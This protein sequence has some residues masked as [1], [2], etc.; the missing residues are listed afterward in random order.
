MKLIFVVKYYDA[1]RAAFYGKNKDLNMLTYDQLMNRYLDDY[2]S[3]YSSL[4]RILRTRGHEA[5]LIIPNCE[6]IRAKWNLK[7]GLKPVNSDKEYISDA[8]DFY[9][10]DAVFLNSNFEYC[11]DFAAGIRKKVKALFCWISCPYDQS[12]NL[13]PFNTIF[14][15]FPPHH[16]TF[17][18]SGLHSKLVTAGFDPEV[19]KNINPDTKSSIPFS[20]VGGIGG[21]HKK[22]EKYLKQIAKNTPLQ[23][24]GYGYSSDHLLKRILKNVKNGFTY[25]KNY[26]GQAWGVDMFQVLNDSQIT[27]NIHG[28]IAGTYSVNM[29]LFEATGMGTMLLTDHADNISELFTPGVE[30]V[31]FRTPEEAIEKYNYYSMHDQERK[32]IAAAG[33][34]K[35]LELYNYNNIADIFIEEFTQSIKE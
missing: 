33:Q 10:P 21:F 9:K 18:K 4:I 20:F 17:I 23:I 30:I 13:S 5:E 34:K 29:R 8:I 27:L 16:E 11:G 1:Y 28:D 3:F 6:Q 14:T 26:R 15:L 31:T 32:K 12:L 7:S 25:S 22:R 2:F 19:L 24:W 35:T